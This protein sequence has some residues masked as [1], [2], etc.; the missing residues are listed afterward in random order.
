MYEFKHIN[1]TGIRIF[2][3]IDNKMVSLNS[4]ACKDYSRVIKLQA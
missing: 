4:V 2:L 3:K 1:E